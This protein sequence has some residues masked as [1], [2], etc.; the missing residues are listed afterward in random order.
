[1]PP[2]CLGMPAVHS[3]PFFIPSLL[4]GG[5][6]QLSDPLL[7]TDTVTLFLKVLSVRL[8]A[9]PSIQA[10]L[11][12]AGISVSFP[13]H[14]MGHRPCHRLPLHK[15]KYFLGHGHIVIFLLTRK[16]TCSRSLEASSRSQCT[17]RI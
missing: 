9:L 10:P 2:L 7:V 12:G 6:A 8:I 5:A 4:Q 3:S 14:A 1:M 15:G 13:G 16:E 11:F 17:G